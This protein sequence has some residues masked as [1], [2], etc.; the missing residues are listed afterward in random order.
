MKSPVLARLA[1][2]IRANSKLTRK[3]RK[4][5]VVEATCHDDRFLARDMASALC[6]RIALEDFQD[7]IGRGATLEFERDGMLVRVSDKHSWS[8]S[9]S[10]GWV[11]VPDWLEKRA[12]SWA[13]GY[14]AVGTYAVEHADGS[15]LVG[16]DYGDE[17]TRGA[18]EKHGATPGVSVKYM[19]MPS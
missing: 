3:V 12:Y 16:V 14:C 6:E 7:G 19:A 9:R 11:W 10:I 15:I 5:I 8:R 17:A 18:L 1:R 2:W 13:I 4:V